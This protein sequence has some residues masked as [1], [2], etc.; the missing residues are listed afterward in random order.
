[1]NFVLDKKNSMIITPPKTA[2]FG[3]KGRPRRFELSDI[4]LWMPSL[5]WE[6]GG[7]S[8]SQIFE[9]SDQQHLLSLMQDFGRKRKISE[10][11]AIG[12]L[13]ALD[14]IPETYRTWLMG[15]LDNEGA[16]RSGYGSWK[17]MVYG[18]YAA[19]GTWPPEVSF[20]AQNMLDLE[21]ALEA[22]TT[23]WRNGDLVLCADLLDSSSIASQYL[24]PGA[25]NIIRHGEA[26]NDPQVI[27]L[28]ILAMMEI[29][30]STIAMLDVHELDGARDRV[31]P[32][33]EVLFPDLSDEAAPSA[34]ALFF[35]WLE[36]FSGQVG[37]LAKFI[38]QLSKPR[39]NLDI[40]SSKRQLRRWRSGGKFPSN[41]LLDAMF[42]EL[43]PYANSS[44]EGF[45]ASIQVRTSQ[46]M[47]LLTR[48]INMIQGLVSHLSQIKELVY[49]FG[50]SSA[51]SWRQNRYQH[52][53]RLWLDLRIAQI[54]SA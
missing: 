47:V 6:L 4:F 46:T 8:A 38:P 14:T 33:S 43:Y 18:R 34:N 31:Q 39:K 21:E 49:P 54:K 27:L 17:C 40:D 23:A 26:P 16:I 22:P 15:A 3:R 7:V 12:M 37:C 25:T 35:D 51:Q 20:L 52:W 36:K 9:A 19:T 30:L 42:R 24:W 48:R 13:S 41:E 44:Q 29:M 11:R 1:M 28:R 10:K 2:S 45:E 50:H 5:E 53:Y 32:Y